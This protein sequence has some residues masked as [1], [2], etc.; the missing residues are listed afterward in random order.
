MIN[1]LILLAAINSIQQKQYISIP[2]D[3]IDSTKDKHKYDDYRVQKNISKRYSKTMTNPICQPRNRG[4][5]H[6]KPIKMT[7]VVHC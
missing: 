4:T 1:Q 3:I 2:S 5:N 6:S 7:R